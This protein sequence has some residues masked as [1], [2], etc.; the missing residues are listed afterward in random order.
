MN[1]YFESKLWPDRLVELSE[2]AEVTI[3]DCA[4]SFGAQLQSEIDGV[5]VQIKGI[6]VRSFSLQ[7]THFC[8]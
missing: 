2:E 4:K 1:T 7:K 3:K 8:A 6:E 5:M